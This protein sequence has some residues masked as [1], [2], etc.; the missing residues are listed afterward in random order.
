MY[1]R[2][3]ICLLLCQFLN[4]YLVIFFSFFLFRKFRFVLIPSSSAHFLTSMNYP[5][6][7]V[8]YRGS[9]LCKWLRP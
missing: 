2:A 6:F 5:N 9:R 8:V 1:V 4:V 3:R 7:R